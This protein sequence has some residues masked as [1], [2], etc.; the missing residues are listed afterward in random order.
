MLGYVITTAVIALGSFGG[1]WYSKGKFASK[2]E[3]DV[4]RL[5]DAIARLETSVKA[6][7][8]KVKAKL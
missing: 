8:T 3:A 2:A 7:L 1:G 6:A 4:Q 5:H